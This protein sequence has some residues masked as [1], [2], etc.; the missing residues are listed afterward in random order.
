MPESSQ[1]R[2][3]LGR[4]QG[5]HLFHE[6]PRED[7][8]RE[9]LDGDGVVLGQAHEPGRRHDVGNDGIVH[10]RTSSGQTARDLGAN[11][12][13]FEE[14][15]DPVLPVEDRVVA[16]ALSTRSVIGLQIFQNPGRLGVFFGKR[17]APHREI[18][19]P[20]GHDLL[21]EQHRVVFE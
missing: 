21:L 13:P 4:S 11:Q 5:P 17:D 19:L 18:R 6:M 15:P 9:G 7:Q 12:V 1:E 8:L 14:F 16:P 2:V 20:I 3:R 10:Q